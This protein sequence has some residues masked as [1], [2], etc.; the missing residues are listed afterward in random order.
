MATKKL[1][2]K[3]IRKKKCSYPD[4]PDEGIPIWMATFA[5]MMTL[6]FAFFVLLFSMSTMD[7]VKYSAFQNAQADK[8]G[9]ESQAEGE[10]API[11]SQ[12]EI[13]E[14]LEK[15]VTSLESD[16]KDKMIEKIESSELNERIKKEKIKEIEENEPLK[17]SH[18]PRGV[19]L[20]IDGKLPVEQELYIEN[21]VYQE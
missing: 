4:P 9:G 12:V 7:P 15:M 16:I 8:K 5:D 2:N 1:K 20:E 10:G 3:D 19:A 11:K 13:K 18:D 6:L 21:L 14:E 17:V